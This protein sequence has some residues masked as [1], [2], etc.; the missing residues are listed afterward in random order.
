MIEIH[1]KGIQG[2]IPIKPPRSSNFSSEF[3]KHLNFETNGRCSTSHRV[4]RETSMHAALVGDK[5]IS[6]IH[7][8]NALCDAHTSYWTTRRQTCSS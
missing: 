4:S 2:E 8:S 7:R 3:R 1:G 5:T 6:S